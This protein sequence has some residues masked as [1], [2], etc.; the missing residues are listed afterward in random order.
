M[1]IPTM[2]VKSGDSFAIINVD[3]YDPKIHETYDPKPA[4]GKKK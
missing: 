4:A 1:R 3:D 2:K